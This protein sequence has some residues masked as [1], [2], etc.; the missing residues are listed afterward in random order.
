[1]LER[2]KYRRQLRRFRKEKIHTKKE[3]GAYIKKA[4]NEDEKDYMIYE[5]RNDLAEKDLR[6]RELQTVHFCRE[7]DKLLIPKPDWNDE[8]MWE[9]FKNPRLKRIVLT[10]KGVSDL[11]ARIRDERKERREIYRDWA[12]II[13]GILGALIGVGNYVE[14]WTKV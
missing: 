5:M 6:V 13:I 9:G 1:M 12:A 3:H 11:M 2:I 8:G 7:A 4:T 10:T 14:L